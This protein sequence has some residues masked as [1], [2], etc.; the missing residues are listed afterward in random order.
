MEP[1]AER[2]NALE[3]IAYDW[4]GRDLAAATA[5]ANNIDDAALRERLLAAGAKAI[6]VADPDLA[7]GWLVSSVKTEGLLN[8]TAL[9]LVET[10][11]DQHPMQ[12]A[13]WVSHF[14]E[15]GPRKAAIDLVLS[16]WVKTDPAS[17]NAWI[18]TLPEREAV[19]AKLK[20]E[21]EEREKAPEK[22]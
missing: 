10:W 17:A 2:T 19:L 7:A 20:A 13:N 5:W 3:T 6:A 11:A 16:H 14:S 15:A 4:F 21:Q 12:A 18:Q 9:G 22:E 8:E 1:G